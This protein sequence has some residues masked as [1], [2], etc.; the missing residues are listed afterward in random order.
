MRFYTKQHRFYG[1]VNLHARTLAV[2][3]F[4]A[5]VPTALTPGHGTCIPNLHSA[6]ANSFHHPYIPL[7]TV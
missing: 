5:S 3:I 6:I 2:Y 4:N 7:V 1:G